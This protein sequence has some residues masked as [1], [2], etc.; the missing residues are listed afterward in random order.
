VQ[1]DFSLMRKL[2]HEHLVMGLKDDFDLGY[3]EFW[4]VKGKNFPFAIN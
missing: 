4:G 1:T 2:M 3:F